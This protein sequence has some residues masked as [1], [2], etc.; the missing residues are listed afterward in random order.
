MERVTAA[1]GGVPLV[2]SRYTMPIITKELR[3]VF[4]I[5]ASGL[6]LPV[7]RGTKMYQILKANS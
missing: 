2:V 5:F 7:E 1:F 6:P 4:G 3:V